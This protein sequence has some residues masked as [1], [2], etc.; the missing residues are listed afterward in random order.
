MMIMLCDN[1][2]MRPTN[3]THKSRIETFIFEIQK[4]NLNITNTHTG[5][6]TE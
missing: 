1:K 5:R 3:H 2:M 4:K 6:Q